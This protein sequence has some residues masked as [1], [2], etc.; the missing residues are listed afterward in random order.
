MNDVRDVS[1]SFGGR[2]TYA[3]ISSAGTIIKGVNVSAK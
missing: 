1:M 3:P 2:L